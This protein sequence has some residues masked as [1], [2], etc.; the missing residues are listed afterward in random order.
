MVGYS[1]YPLSKS[2]IFCSFTFTLPSIV[3]TIESNFSNYQEHMPE[4]EYRIR[5]TQTKW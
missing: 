5:L 4:S 1:Q 2:V 3:W